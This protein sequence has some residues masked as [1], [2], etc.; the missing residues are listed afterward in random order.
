MNEKTKAILIGGVALGLLSSIPVISL[1]NCCCLWMLGGGAL[2]VYLYRPHAATPLTLGDGA[3]LGAL[4]G[5]VG[6]GV[7]IV[8]GVPLGL[9]FES[10]LYDV[11]T[12]AALAVMPPD[13]GAE[14][15]RS[16]EQARAQPFAQ[17]L[18][19]IALNMLYTGV[20][21]VV[22]SLVGGTLG[23]ELFDKRRKT[24]LNQPPPPPPDFTNGPRAAGGG[25]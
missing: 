23:V 4:A 12:R 18:L 19:F 2:T 25:G 17:R 13:A 3:T 1:A 8:V 6:T 20:I 15:S 11:M 21:T 24:Q 10:T 14:F 22:I 7:M 9:L 16:L 5:L